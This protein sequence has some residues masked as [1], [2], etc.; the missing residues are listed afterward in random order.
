M[1]TEEQDTYFFMWLQLRQADL[2]LPIISERTSLP[3]P[4]KEK[5]RAQLARCPI[6]T[7]VGCRNTIRIAN[8]EHI[9]QSEIT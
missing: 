4:S 8:P 2:V 5:A 3:A 7:L 1:A 6:W 9:M